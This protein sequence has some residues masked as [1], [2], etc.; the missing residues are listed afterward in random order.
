MPTSQPHLRPW[1]RPF[2]LI[3]ALFVVAFGFTAYA[4]QFSE[5]AGRLTTAPNYDDCVYLLR[6]VTLLDEAEEGGVQGFMESLASR[7][8]HSPYSVFMSTAAYGVTDNAEAAPYWSNMA[9]VVL[10]LSGVTWWFRKLPIPIIVCAWLAFLSVPFAG[11]MVM[12]FRPDPLWAVVTGFGVCWIWMDERATSAPWRSMLAG[13][14]FGAALVIK[15]TTFAMTV[16]VFIS[17]WVGR[18]ILTA[19]FHSQSWKQ[20]AW[21]MNLG[22]LMA[23]ALMAGPYFLYN[24]AYVWGYFWDNSFGI[25]KDVWQHPGDLREQITY[26]LTGGGGESNIGVPGTIL[27]VSGALAG[28]FWLWKSNWEKRLQLAALFCALFC[29]YAVNVYGNAKTP[30]LGG[31]IYSI[32]Y[33]FAAACLAH[34]A[35]RMFEGAKWKK[36]TVY[37]ASLALAGV[38]LF[39]QTWPPY[40]VWNRKLAGTYE[41]N[42]EAFSLLLS[43]YEEALPDIVL[44]TQLGPVV[45]EAL[46][47]QIID[48]D[49]PVRVLSM[50]FDRDPLKTAKE[51]EPGTWIVTPE[52]GTMGTTP[53]LP[54]EENLGMFIDWLDT[55]PEWEVL[56]RWSTLDGNEI[57]TWVKQPATEELPSPDLEEALPVQSAS[58]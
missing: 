47:M 10:F 51:Q 22:F 1:L 36:Y 55:N 48:H 54:I 26:Y 24:G 11:L 12:E 41:T 34:V 30:F 33:F 44:L 45:P 3:L 46:S 25:N 23:L 15:P 6:A 8:V 17:S 56:T 19:I 31:A 58:E 18:Q 13:L 21:K 42:T 29:V 37:G 38:L 16:L 49:W 14:L 4:V 28:L 20:Q 53:H 57:I 9:I 7:P 39:L 32:A 43:R 2:L 5:A 35:T 52:P 50:A 40:S 27:L